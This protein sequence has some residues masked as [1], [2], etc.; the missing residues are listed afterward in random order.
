MHKSILLI[1]L[2]L[3]VTE[4]FGQ[5]TV[6]N[7][8]EFSGGLDIQVGPDR[9]KQ[10]WNTGGGGSFTY[11]RYLSDAFSITAGLALNRFSI[12]RTVV[13]EYVS[14]Q[15]PDSLKFLVDFLNITDGGVTVTAGRLGASYDFQLKDSSFE[16]TNEGKI[17]FY[18][19]AAVGVAYN[20]INDLELQL[21]GE[22]AS[23]EGISKT[24]LT[25]EG[26]G[27]FRFFLT[28]GLGLSAEA[29]FVANF[30]EGDTLTYLPIRLG[31]FFR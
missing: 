16:D 7:Q 12:D 27:G 14:G 24:G 18:T 5:S 15:L 29:V 21:L 28:N 23:V 8:F 10:F 4:A 11:S 9:L 17:F 31:V 22:Q 30:L 1:I 2:L 19:R 20:A 13:E 3:P 6:R 26:G 25:V